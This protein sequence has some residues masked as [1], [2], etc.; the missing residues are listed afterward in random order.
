M[1]LAKKKK[2]ISAKHDMKSALKEKGVKPLKKWLI[3]PR[4]SLLKKI[5]KFEFEKDVSDNQQRIS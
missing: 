4:S 1:S 3:F 5:G 2:I